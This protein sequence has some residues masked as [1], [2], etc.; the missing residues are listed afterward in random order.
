MCRGCAY[1]TQERGTDGGSTCYCNWQGRN[2]N[3]T[4]H[5]ARKTHANISSRV[6]PYAL[7]HDTP[8]SSYLLY[9]LE[10][11]RSYPRE[12]QAPVRQTTLSRTSSLHLLCRRWMKKTDFGNAGLTTVD[13]RERQVQTHSRFITLTQKML[14]HVHH[15]FQ[16]VREDPWRCTH[17][18]ESQVEIQKFCGSLIQRKRGSLLSVARLGNI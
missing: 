12:E 4:P 2:V 7:Q 18:R 9:P 6:A 5:R 1:G 3:S 13:T 16:P 17:T 8:T 11:L 10:R 14:S 15:T